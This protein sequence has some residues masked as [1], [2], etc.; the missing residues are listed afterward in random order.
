MLTTATA[1]NI[2]MASISLTNTNISDTYVGVLHAKGAAIPSS[3][4]QDVYDGAGNKSALKIGRTGVDIDG[5]I[6]DDFKNAIADAIY[7]INTVLFSTDNNNPGV[8]F[9]GTTWEQVAEGRFIA[10]VGTGTDGNESVAIAAGNDS[11]GEYNHQLTE[12]ELPAHN[13]PVKW[14]QG[15]NQS[16]G[17]DTSSAGN[18]YNGNDR[19]STDNVQTT[20]SNTPHNNIPPTFGMYMWKRTS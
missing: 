2:H 7:P 18:S 8:R 15:G 1:I 4:L 19:L 16:L 3:G 17:G 13:H 14:T 10:S 6:G 9:A 11:V 12:P 20:G 5:T